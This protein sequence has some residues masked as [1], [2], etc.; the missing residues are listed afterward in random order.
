M[1]W[2]DYTHAKHFGDGIFRPYS[3]FLADVLLELDNLLAAE[4]T[5]AGSIVPFATRDTILVLGESVSFVAISRSAHRHYPLFATYHWG[6]LWQTDERAMIAK[7]GLP[8]DGAK[9]IAHLDLDN[10]LA[11]ALDFV[12][13]I[14]FSVPSVFQPKPDTPEVTARAKSITE[15]ARIL[16]AVERRRYEVMLEMNKPKEIFLSHKSF[17]KAL[18]REIAQTLEVIGFHPWLDEDK[19]KAG[20]NLE[21]AIRD[22]FANSCAAVFFVT[23][24]FTDEG[25]LATEID[26]AL[27]EKRAKGD[28]FAII[29]LLLQD[30]TGKFGSVPQMIKQYVWKEVE[31][32]QIIRTIVESLPL[33]MEGPVWRA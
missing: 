17:D 23:P 31:P 27:A 28:R 3:D 11:T 18:V 4:P 29:T 13:P 25:F 12:D 9:Q 26:Y 21:R 14:V 1:S 24:H 7:L 22:G 16:L 6:N 30:S 2:A 10:H 5:F 15:A 33:R 32:I 8:L 19:M 20:A